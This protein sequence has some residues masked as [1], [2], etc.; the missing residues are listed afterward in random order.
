MWVPLNVGLL[1]KTGPPNP[2][3]CLRIFVWSVFFGCTVKKTVN[4]GKGGASAGLDD[5]TYDEPLDD[6]YD[7]M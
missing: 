5:Y 4:V 2:L 1:L 7:F 6:D 3:I